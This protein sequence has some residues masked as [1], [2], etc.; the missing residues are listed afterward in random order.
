[1]PPIDLQIHR[2]VGVVRTTRGGA[3]SKLS[4]CVKKYVELRLLVR[5]NYYCSGNIS[6]SLFQ[7][8]KK[9]DLYRL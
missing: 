6:I 3:Q 9:Y 7:M 2:G 1:M 8:K 4:V 5:P